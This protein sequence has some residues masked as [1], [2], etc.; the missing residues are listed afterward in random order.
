VKTGGPSSYGELL[1]C[2]EV[3]RDAKQFREEA[4]LMRSDQSVEA[5][6]RSI[7]HRRR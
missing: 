4:S 1:S 3:F 6:P 5:A 7:H 2:T